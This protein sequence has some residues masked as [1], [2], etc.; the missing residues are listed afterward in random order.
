MQG[1]VKNWPGHMAQAIT[2]RFKQWNDEIRLVILKN[3]IAVFLS[4]VLGCDLLPP[5]PL[6]ACPGTTT[7]PF[8]GL[9]LEREPPTTHILP[10]FCT[11]PAALP[12]SQPLCQHS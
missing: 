1:G 9:W 11:V 6:W 2:G 7:G 10:H 12:L 8:P 3:L 4:L 5:S